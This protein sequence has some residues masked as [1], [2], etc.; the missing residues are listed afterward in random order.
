MGLVG[1][2]ID[3]I[4]EAKGDDIGLQAVNDGASLFAG[5]S[6]RLFYLDSLACFQFPIGGNYNK[7][8]RN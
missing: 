1:Y 5:P 6:V 4:G 3:V 2:G 8:A 7:Q